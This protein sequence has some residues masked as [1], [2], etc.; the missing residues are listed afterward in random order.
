MNNLTLGSLFDGSGGFS[1]GRLD[2]RHHT[3]VGIGDRAVSH[4]GH[5]QAPA[6]YETLR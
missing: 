2:F 3:C 5:D 1:V 4:S 6:L